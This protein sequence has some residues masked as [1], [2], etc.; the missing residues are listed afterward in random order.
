MLVEGC[1]HV[2]E[3]V[4]RLVNKREI[5]M[6]KE[7]QLLVLLNPQLLVGLVDDV[8][9]GEINIFHIVGSFGEMDTFH[10]SCDLYVRL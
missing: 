1:V 3:F 10:I 6:H 4:S 7:M 9:T 2:I 8:L 5:Q